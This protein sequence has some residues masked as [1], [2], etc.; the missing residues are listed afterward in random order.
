M[1]NRPELNDRLTH[2]Q[3]PH[4][5]TQGGP[6]NGVRSPGQATDRE[7]SRVAGGNLTPRRSQNRVGA[8]LALASPTPPGMRVR[9][10]R[11]AQH[12]RKR[13]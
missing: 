10:G 2:Y 1:T 11:F 5:L 12:S 4:A 13:R 7:R 3:P 6:I 8:R 9:T